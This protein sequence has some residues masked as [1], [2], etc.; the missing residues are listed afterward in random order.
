MSF[1]DRCVLCTGGVFPNLDRTS[2]MTRGKTWSAWHQAIR[3]AWGKGREPSAASRGRRYANGSS[4]GAEMR[5]QS[6]LG[7]PLPPAGLNVL[8]SPVYSPEQ[9][10]RRRSVTDWRDHGRSTFRPTARRRSDRQIKTLQEADDDSLDRVLW[11]SLRWL[12][13]SRSRCCSEPRPAS[14]TAANVS[15]SAKPTQ[16]I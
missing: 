14:V 8:P 15:S 3:A 4:Q 1:Y 16:D 7:M 9:C 10:R 12:S 11:S 6:R 13:S 2:G 5:R